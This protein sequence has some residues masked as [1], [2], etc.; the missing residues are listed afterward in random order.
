[1]VGRYAHAKALPGKPW[2]GH[3]SREVIEE[4]QSLTDRPVIF[5]GQ[6]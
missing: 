6:Q 4:T 5:T 1:M 2:D 3:T